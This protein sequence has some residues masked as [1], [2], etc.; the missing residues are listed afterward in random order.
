MK[1]IIFSIFRGLKDVIRNMSVQSWI[2]PAI[3]R[4]KRVIVL[5]GQKPVVVVDDTARQ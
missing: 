3:L 1:G 4:Y 5:R 2:D